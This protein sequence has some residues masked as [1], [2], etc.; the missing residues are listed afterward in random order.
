MV[1]VPGF[2]RLGGSSWQSIF[3]G[4]GDIETDYLNGE[5]VWLGRCH[6][7]ATPANEVCQGVALR[8]LRDGLA[9]GA[10]TSQEIIEL[11][12]VRTG[13]DGNQ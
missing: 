10:I 1:E 12:E 8:L 11:I 13:S 2:P 9:T 3:R 6:G 7:V 5:I 4:T